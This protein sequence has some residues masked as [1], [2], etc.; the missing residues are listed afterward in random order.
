MNRVLFDETIVPHILD[1]AGNDPCNRERR[2]F[3]ISRRNCYK[4]GDI[5]QTY[6][7]FNYETQKRRHLIMPIC[8]INHG[9]YAGKL[10]CE[11]CCRRIVYRLR[12]AE[13][14]FAD[15]PYEHVSHADIDLWND[16]KDDDNGRK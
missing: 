13:V 10:V 7:V 4:C 14:V 8:K 1:E 2:E 15:R 3:T 11:T 12:Q 16:D 6:H 5:F 9:P